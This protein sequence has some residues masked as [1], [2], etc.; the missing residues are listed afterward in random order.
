M[1][2]LRTR[3]V[4]GTVVLALL[5][6][7][8]GCSGGSAGGTPAA[9]DTATGT[10]TTADAAGTITATTT[11]ES[12]TDGGDDLARGPV[13][14]DYVFNDSEGY[15][16]VVDLAN[17]TTKM[18]WVV[19]SAA[20]NPRA[21]TDVTVNVRFDQF[22]TNTTAPQGGI[23]EEVING[24]SVGESFLHVRTPVVLAAGH[25]LTVGNSWTI[26]QGNVTVGDGFEIGRERAT[27]EITGT[28]SVAGETCYTM[29]LRMSDTETGPASCL[30][31]DWPFALAVDTPGRDY[32]LSEF[33]RP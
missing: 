15:G 17:G 33:D 1:G 14:R 11:A 30:K 27:A 3:T 19:T 23:F 26:E 7:L 9:T 29:E 16:Y 18:S 2:T 4:G 12:E 28:E 20:A 22:G 8:A 10:N 21:Y 5:L 6:V 31:A 25:N 24:G 13:E 32:R